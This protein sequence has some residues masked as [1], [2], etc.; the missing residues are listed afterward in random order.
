MLFLWWQNHSQ[1]ESARL[2]M[3]VPFVC[4]PIETT[5]CVT[6]MFLLPGISLPA[7]PQISQNDK[8]AFG[9]NAKSIKQC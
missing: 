8:G 5:C 6:K 2:G 4:R 7:L 3:C 9:R 1:Q